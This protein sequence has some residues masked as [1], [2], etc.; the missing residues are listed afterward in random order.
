VKN[1]FSKASRF[2]PAALVVLGWIAFGIGFLTV[3]PV[4]LKLNCMIA[5]R[6][7]PHTALFSNSK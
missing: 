2:I 4:W 5:S 1:V 7:L 6:V 3:K